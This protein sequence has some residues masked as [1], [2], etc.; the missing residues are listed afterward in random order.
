M[1]K[2]PVPYGGGAKKRKRKSQATPVR[3]PTPPT[4]LQGRPAKEAVP[5]PAAPRG[6]AR[7]PVPAKA[8]SVLAFAT[9]QRYVISDL[10]RIGVI[11]GGM[12]A[13]LIALA[14]IMR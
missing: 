3:A 11:T 9:E 14:F 10:K 6:E 8:P 13:L 4:P 2:K 1:P 12:L 7:G 5:R